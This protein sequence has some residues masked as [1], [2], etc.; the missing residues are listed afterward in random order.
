MHVGDTARTDTQTDELTTAAHKDS[1]HMTTDWQERRELIAGV[2]L[3]EVRNV[4]TGN[5]VT[6][7]VWRR[8]WPSGLGDLNQLIHVRLRPS[9][10]SAWHLHRQRQDGIFV[11]GGMMRV[12]LF[13][14]RRHSATAGKLDVLHL[15][16]VRPTLVV[17]PPSVWHGVQVLGNEP[18]CFINCFDRAYDYDDPDE[19]RLPPDTDEIPYRFA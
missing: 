12:V 14:P 17:V 18:A 2:S 13:D 10:V 15:S 9:A 3:R 19:W 16:H 1:A 8:E 7:E 4:V 5:G 11:V 6:T